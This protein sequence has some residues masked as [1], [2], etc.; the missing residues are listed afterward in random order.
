[1]LHG[2]TYVTYVRD[3][4]Y[5][6]YNYTKD[7]FGPN[8]ENHCLFDLKCVAYEETKNCTRVEDMWN[9]TKTLFSET[10]DH[11]GRLCSSQTLER[12]EDD[13]PYIEKLCLGNHR[14]ICSNCPLS[15]LN[16]C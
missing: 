16:K 15:K 1:M 5:G 10:C 6:S 11:Y 3:D 8:I 4:D 14:I 13:S 2:T 12:K 7:Y 9:N